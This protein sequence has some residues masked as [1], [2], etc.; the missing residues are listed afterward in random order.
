ML[1][2]SNSK[3]EKMDMLHEMFKAPKVCRLANRVVVNRYDTLGQE[4]VLTLN[5]DN[6]TV[7]LPVK[8]GV[9]T[10]TL[11]L[12]GRAYFLLR[13]KKCGVT[14]TEISMEKAIEFIAKK[15]EIDESDIAGSVDKALRHC[16]HDEVL[17]K[18]NR[19]DPDNWEFF[20]RAFKQSGNQLM[21]FYM[22]LAITKFQG[23]L[24]ASNKT[25]QFS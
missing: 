2:L 1:A 16:F 19:R 22:A 18:I 20:M 23:F 9:S 13:H 21:E 6:T 8:A 5:H 12:H 25:E 7:V 14:F 17:P 15:P 24:N 4:F 11:P 3:W 10:T